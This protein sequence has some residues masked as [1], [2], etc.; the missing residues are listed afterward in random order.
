MITEIKDE[1]RNWN[2]IVEEAEGILGRL[3]IQQGEFEYLSQIQRGGFTLVIRPMREG[4]TLH[5]QPIAWQYT[6]LFHG[7]THIARFHY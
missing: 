3:K 6:D 4:I 1:A 7:P 5:G 2:P